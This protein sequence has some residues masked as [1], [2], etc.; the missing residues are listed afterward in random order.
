RLTVARRCR[1]AAAANNKKAG[2]TMSE[3]FQAIV[4]AIEKDDPDARE[5]AVAH[6]RERVA[7]I[8]AKLSALEMYAEMLRQSPARS[9][10]LKQYERNLAEFK[11]FC[12][13][14]IE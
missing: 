1:R 11:A 12:D 4:A 3:D 6:F 14:K 8:K 7:P 13:Q 2:V 9:E 5:R 10:E